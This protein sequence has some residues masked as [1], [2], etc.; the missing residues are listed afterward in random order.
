[1]R[2]NLSLILSLLML[3]GLLAA[4]EPTWV[5]IDGGCTAPSPTSEGR[6]AAARVTRTS[7]PAATT[8]SRTWT[9]CSTRCPRRRRAGRVHSRRDGDRS[10]A[11][12]YIEQLVLEVPEGV[13]LAGDRGQQR[14]AKAPCSPATRSRR[15]SMI[16]ATGPN[17]RVTGLRI[18]GPNPKRYLDH[19]RRAF[20]PGGGRARVLLQVPDS[21]RHLD[22]ARRVSKSTTATSP[23]S[24][25]PASA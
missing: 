6:S 4:D 21:R 1:M 19:H 7:S 8:R 13:T 2:T 22:R 24:A 9:P 11:R 14:F 3:P 20:G 15:R 17:V 16:R 5:E 18:R 23:V 12:I 25:T 10:D